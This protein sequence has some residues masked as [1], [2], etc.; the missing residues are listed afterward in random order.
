MGQHISDAS[1]PEFNPP[2]IFNESLIYGADGGKIVYV[3]A[4]FATVR[5]CA[6]MHAC[7]ASLYRSLP[8]NTAM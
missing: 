4:M 7:R 1:R 5:A 8:S 2:Q 6:C 3:E